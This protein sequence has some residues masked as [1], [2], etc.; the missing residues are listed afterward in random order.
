MLVHNQYLQRGGEDAVVEAEAELLRRRGHDVEHYIRHNS[1]LETRAPVTTAMNAIWNRASARDL[2]LLVER[3]RPD[4]VH[5]HNYFPMI[6]ASALWAVHSRGVP[7]VQTLHNF[8]LLCLQAMLLRDGRPCEACVGR[9]PWRG[10]VRRCYRGSVAQSAVLATSLAVHRAAGTVRHKVD[11][12]ICLT[13][14]ARRKFV[15]G[16]L[17][18]ADLC[19]KPNFVDLP[20]P[21]DGPRGGGL[22][23]GRLSEDKG[24][25]VL[26]EALDLCASAS[27][28]VVG[29]GPLRAAL[30]GHPRIELR[31]WLDPTEVYRAMRESAFLVM[32]SL[33]YE[34]FPRTL[35]EAYACGL[36]VIASSLGALSELVSDRRTGL[37]FEPGS[38]DDLARKIRWAEE[39]PAE[40]RQMGEQARREYELKYTPEINYTQ[41][42]SIYDSATN[43]RSNGASA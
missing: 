18:V 36:P 40:T 6:S 37:L 32:P 1:E 14:F 10:I 15:E 24:V 12:Y 21:S 33:W 28:A 31:G 39:H 27:L 9:L 3:F 38:V 8:R 26:R 42:M 30:E 11:R 7:V 5:V 2:A 19:V 43:S 29:D 22:F 13:E 20:A 41:L 34:G 35:V 16:G 17:A 23:V 4:I 25:R